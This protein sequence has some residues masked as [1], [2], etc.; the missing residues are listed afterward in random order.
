MDKYEVTNALYKTCVDAGLCSQPNRLN[1]KTRAAYYGNAQ[2]DHY[3]VIYV[4]W[5]QAVTYCKWRGGRL[6]TEAEWEY[7]ARGNDGRI[8]PWGNSLDITRV[9][10]FAKDTDPV[11]SYPAGQSFFG[12]YDMAG[13]V[14][15][16]VHDWYD[17]HYYLKLSPFNPQGPASGKSRVVRGGGWDGDVNG[18]RAARRYGGDPT[19]H[20][21]NLGFR[22]AATP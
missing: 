5:D 4:D 17:A 20:I 1:S 19:Y 6:P 13:N 3:P 8:Y 18:P 22:C 21:D 12:L 9:I 16:W 14:Q 11:G 10:Y 7:A 15:E 2:F